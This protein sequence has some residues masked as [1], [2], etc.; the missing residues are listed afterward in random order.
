MGEENRVEIESLKDADVI[1]EAI[2]D[3][4]ITQAGLA[5]LLG[6]KH[7]SSVSGRLSGKSMSTER[8]VT[9]LSAMG[10][11]VV[12]RKIETDETTGEITKRD[13]WKVAPAEHRNSGNKPRER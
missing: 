13:M 1:R 11:E 3:Q 6:Y 7:Q 2:L 12:V 5:S 10:Y 8:F 4:G 9:M